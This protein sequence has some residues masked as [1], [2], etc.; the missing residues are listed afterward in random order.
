MGATAILQ[1]VIVLGLWTAIMMLW[2]Y[3]TRIPAMNKAGMDPQAAQHVKNIELPSN[4][5]RIADNYNHLFEQPTLFYATAL[6]IAVMGHGDATNVMLAW[7]FVILRII[8]SLVQATINIVMLRFS[9]FVLSWL[10]LIIML[11]REAVV[12]F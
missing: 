1:P 10:V 12:I 5:A 3:A 4:V 11:V 9:I 2:M 7:T 8:H 6:T